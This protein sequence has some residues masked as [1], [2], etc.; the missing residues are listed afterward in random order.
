MIE[1]VLIAL[2]WVNLIVLGLVLA[3]NVV[4]SWLP[5]Q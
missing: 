2:S 4:G 3:Y 1:R 5:G